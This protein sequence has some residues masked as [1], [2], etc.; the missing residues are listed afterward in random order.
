V[1]KFSI[2][3]PRVGSADVWPIGT[4]ASL[5]S[6]IS[7]TQQGRHCLFCHRTGTSREHILADWIGRSLTGPPLPGITIRFTHEST[8]PD[9]TPLRAKSAASTAYY[10]RAFC[11]ECNGGWMSRLEDAVKPILEPMLHGRPWTTLS[12]E[13]QRLLAFWATKTAFAFQTQEGAET[14]WARP[15]Q[16]EALYAEQ[17]PLPGS[18]VWLGAREQFHA[19]WY[20]SHSLRL[21]GA[22]EDQVD[23][24]GAALSLGFAVF[25]LIVPDNPNVQVRL[26]SEAA[27]MMKPI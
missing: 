4:A 2:L 3:S 9:G 8:M 24:F 17:G 16:F 12:V 25:W 6:S 11:R 7:M 18:Q 21:P 10:T 26:V 27:M 22:P 15:Q 20:R 5:S 14:T 23:G 19:A 1:S 13:D